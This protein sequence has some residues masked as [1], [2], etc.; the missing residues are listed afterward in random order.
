MGLFERVKVL[1]DDKIIDIDTVDRLYGYRV[2]NIV[3]NETIRQ[4]KLEREKDSY[5]D[6]AQK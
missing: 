6:F 2:D 1:V 5:L 4:A 3:N